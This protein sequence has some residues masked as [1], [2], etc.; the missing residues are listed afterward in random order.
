MSRRAA[1]RRLKLVSNALV[2]RRFDALPDAATAIDLLRIVNA[3]APAGKPVQLGSKPLWLHGA[4]EAGKRARRHL[5]AVGQPLAGVVDADA[6]RRAED[7]DWAG[8]PVLAPDRV[9][10]AAKAKGVLA[11]AET[12]GPHVPLATA[13]NAEGWANCVPFADVA[14]AFR[15]Q[16]PGCGG[17]FAEPLSAEELEAAGAVLSGFGDE[18][19]RAHYLRC[20]AWRLARQEW[21]FATVPVLGPERFLVPEVTAALRADERILDGGAYHGDLTARLLEAVKGA[22][23]VVWAAEPDGANRAVLQARVDGLDLHLRA[24]IQVLDAVLGAR[25]EAARFHEG[26]GPASQ[27]A[28][29]GRVLRA[30]A[31]LDALGLDPTVVALDLEGAELAALQGA[32]ETLR[33][34]RPLIMLAISHDATGLVET[35]HWL[36]ENLPDYTVLMRTHGWCGMGAMLYAIPKERIAP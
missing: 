34:R 9:P 26:L 4:G 27:I 32:R 11:L 13:L 7:P 17:W 28:P 5:D 31:P 30:C 35:P 22:I 15:K 33:R 36:I 2:A 6:A 23:S 8:I 18:A 24:R 21:E 3:R 10:D 16:R 14:E 1:A 20:A 29:T 25:T 19:S 12:D